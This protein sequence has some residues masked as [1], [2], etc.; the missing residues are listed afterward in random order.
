MRKHC[1]H[2]YYP[3]KSSCCFE[4]I[5]GVYCQPHHNV[6]VL[7]LLKTEETHE[8]ILT[9]CFFPPHTF[10]LIIHWKLTKFW[11]ISL[12]LAVNYVDFF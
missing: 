10:C 1:T 9:W 11:R 8:A 3:V 7:A 12:V 6:G 2:Y 4:K 5:G